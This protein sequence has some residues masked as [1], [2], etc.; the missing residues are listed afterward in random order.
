MRFLLFSAILLC[1]LLLAGFLHDGFAQ[2]A[3]AQSSSG[4]AGK[5]APQLDHFDPKNVDSSIDPC[6]DFYQYSCKRWIAGNPAP[7]DEVF[8][9]AF[10]K[11]QLWNTAALRQTVLAVAAK[12]A[13][14][15]TLVEQKV[16]NYWTA[17]M[18]EKQRN[19]RTLDTL[20]PTLDRIDA[21][22]NTREMAEIV[23][24][25]HRLV[26]GAWNTGDAWTRASLFGFGSA[27]DYHDTSHVIAQFDQGGMG[28]PGREFYLSNDRK[29]ADIRA[30]YVDH[31][32]RL[33]ALAGIPEAQARADA[34]VVLQMETT[35]AKVSMDIVKR[36][37]PTNLDNEMDLEAVKELA[38]SFDWSRYLELVHA[39]PVATYIVTSPD[40]FRGMEQQIN[41]EPLDHW[42]AYLKW[43]LL[44]GEA[45]EMSEDFVN[46]DFA[47][48]AQT[49]FGAK[50]M[51]PL[52][53]RCIESEDR[54]IG[55]ALGQ[56]YAARAFP[57]KSKAR[58]KQ[59]V[60]NLK[61]ALGQDIDSM[62]WMDAE[63]KKQAQ[64]KLA[65]QV[66]KI[67]YPDHWRDYSGLE[68]R[69]DNH[70][71]NVERASEFEF[72]RQLQKIG[73]PVDRTE[74]GMTPPTVNAYED[75]QTNTINFPAG[76]LQPPFFDPAMDDTVNYAAIGAVIGHETIHGY[77]D[78]GRK[79]DA[80]GNLHDWWSAEAA[81]AYDERGDCIAD[82]YTE[83]V[84][85]LGVKQDGRLTQGENTADNG[86][87]HV[88]LSALESDLKRKGG[89]LDAKGRDG[90][91]GW[92]R[93]FLAYANMWCSAWTP[94]M[95]RTAILSNPH[96]LDKY[97]VNNVL[98][99]MAEFA[100]AFG[101]H[102]GQAMV[103][104]NACR[105]W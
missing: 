22:R 80:I 45:A 28:L 9:G 10:G 72:K 90:L 81:T 71:A 79:F 70:L 4:E 7:P 33:L 21:M 92:Q 46:E 23:A 78:Q 77:D 61:A 20:R 93:F 73:K 14:E 86:G 11:L 62:D 34:N 50:T 97:R 103:H 51:E 31:I 39:P 53:R 37:D 36:R 89:S 98:G 84:P 105:V 56:S 76:I 38:P 47:F 88:A 63:T 25:I 12:P 19:L 95:M 13:A 18:N 42:K 5:L 94:E 102:K 75:P 52:W 74:W 48:N 17:C 35:M 65:A 43:T 41:N 91:T 24:E 96:P 15:R 49:I 58:M 68:I 59:M 66:D 29:S 8:W 16:G 101:C 87:I 2:I 55:E 26:P 67:G 27:P 30:Q 32:A 54:N 44:S 99:N 1:N 40:F 57:P 85:E 6:T 60:D 104:A 69:S 100:K 64:I 3:R 82:E 83:F